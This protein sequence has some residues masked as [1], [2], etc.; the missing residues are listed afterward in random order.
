MR[1]QLTVFLALVAILFWTIPAL[2]QDI[3]Q[4]ATQ[5]D[6]EQVKAWVEKDPQLVNF[7]DENGR[8][9]LHW[10]SR[11]VHLDVLKYLVENSANVNATDND[12]VT[13]LHSLSYRDHTEAMEILIQQGANVEFKEING[14]T[15][16][17]YAAYGGQD[18][19]AA[20]LFKYG[21][22]ANVKD[23]TG[24]T[25]ADIA[26]DQ[27]HEELSQYL[28]TMG[29][30]LTPVADPEITELADNIHKITFCYQQCTNML[31]VDGPDD[32]LLIDTGYPRTAEKLRVSIHTIGN[33]KNVTVINTH[34]HY[35]HIGGNNLAGENGN[36]IAFENL[37]QMASEGVLNKSNESLRGA[38]G[39]EH[40][41]GYTL[42]FNHQQVRLIPLTGAHTDG[43]MVV[44]FEDAGIVHLGDLLIS[45]SFPSVTRGKKVIEYMAILETVIDIF[46][47]QT[48][49]VGGHGRNLNKQEL[50]A[51]Q[52]MLEGTIEIVTAG[53]KAGKTAETMRHDGVL[54]KYVT[55]DT[56]IPMLNTGY[57]I[58]TVSKNYEDMVLSS[59]EK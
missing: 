13:A 59:P 52:G 10:A 40:K 49:F 11:G 2:A 32:V 43:D 18:A 46:D 16:L 39:K 47:D 8:T 21:A 58:E 17:M 28:L 56:F 14:L 22:K 33:G 31:V 27:G 30:K 35:D 15:P 23:Q 48:I 5:G 3:N 42:D 37:E 45:E 4:A 19:A 44:H 1:T 7:K 6:L 25:V 29:A 34:Q 20:T 12:G 50:V 41:G 36:I 54:D 51:Y 57:W 26:A 38:S 24:L 53:L 55:Y 9:A